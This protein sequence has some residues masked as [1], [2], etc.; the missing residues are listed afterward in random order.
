MPYN[1]ITRLNDSQT[2]QL[3]ALY[4]LEWWT[5]GRS[6]QDV[7]KMLAGRSLVYGICETETE[8]LAG[9]ARVLSD[10]IFKA[11]IFDVIVHPHCRGRKIGEKLMNN[12]LSDPRLAR[13]RHFE[14]YCLPQLEPFYEKFGFSATVGD[15]RLMRYKRR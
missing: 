8:R 6:L 5:A 1:N 13:V 3:H 10:G 12:L 11:L 15:V 14:L 2:I 9:F 4:Q 7:R